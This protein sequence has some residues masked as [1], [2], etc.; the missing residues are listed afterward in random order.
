[1]VILL[2]SKQFFTYQLIWRKQGFRVITSAV[3]FLVFV[4]RCLYAVSCLFCCI[5]I[6][7]FVHFLFSRFDLE[8]EQFGIDIRVLQDIG[9]IR[10]LF[11]WTEGWEKEIKW[12]NCLVVEGRFLTKYKSLLFKYDDGKIFTIYEGYCEF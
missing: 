1:M 6:E 2:K 10:E 7:K 5:C 8:L 4:N 12:E 9:I 3:L 11:G